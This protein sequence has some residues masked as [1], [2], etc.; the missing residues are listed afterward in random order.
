MSHSAHRYGTVENLRKDYTFYCRTSEGINR[1][2]SESKL[3]ETFEVILSE[4]PTNYG[5]TRAGSFAG[6]LQP[7]AFTKTLNKAIG[8]QCVFSSKEK[9]KN[10]LQKSQKLDHGLSI[11]VG[12]L[13]DEI[14]STAKEIGIRPHTAYLSLGIHGD[15]SLLPD[16]EILEITTMCGHGLVAS[17]L[18]EVVINKINSGKMTPEKGAKFLGRLCTCGIFNTDRCEALFN[19]CTETS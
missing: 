13:I 7:E 10:V 9:I 16:K 5:H 12:G 8:V 19:A 14:V 18:T 1:E 17:K 4:K 15:T 11:V 3:K 2:D 6:G